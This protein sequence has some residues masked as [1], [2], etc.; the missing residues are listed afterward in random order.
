MNHLNPRKNHT[1]PRRSALQFRFFT[2]PLK[3]YTPEGGIQNVQKNSVLHSLHPHFPYPLKTR[4]KR[5]KLGT[6]QHNGFGR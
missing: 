1:P 5:Q 4:L 3:L 6:T 2:I